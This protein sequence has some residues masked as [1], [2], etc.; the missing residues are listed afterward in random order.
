[1]QA[2]IVGAARGVRWLGEGWQLFRA[3][4]LAWLALVFAYWL[5]ITVVS[6]VPYA[7]LAAAAVMVPAFSVG[8]M[9]AARA[10]ERGAR[11]ELGL[12]FEGFRQAPAPQLALG[13]AYFL[14]LGAVV[15]ASS[16]ADGGALAR[17]LLTGGRPDA[18]E[19]Q[20]GELGAAAAT[21]ALLYAPVMMMFWFAPPLAAWHRAPPAKALFF[22]AAAF[23]MN[24]RAFLAYGAACLAATFV[25]SGAMLLCAAALRVPAMALVTPVMIVLLP[26]LFAS[27][28]ASYRDVF[29]IE[30]GM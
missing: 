26:L 24:W 27:F 5:V 22:S 3:A 1:V 15:A 10:A 29:G 20:S 9:A 14:C 12:L 18:Q 25:L 7:G 13:V 2:R 11:L 23:L 6:L 8:F 4:P 16:L 19:V 28:Y 30:D 17:M 21:A